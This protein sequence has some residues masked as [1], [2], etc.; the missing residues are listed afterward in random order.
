MG[1]GAPPPSAILRS[2]SLTSLAALVIALAPQGELKISSSPAVGLGLEAGV[3]RRDPSEVVRIGE[4]DYVCYTKLRTGRPLYPANYAGEIWYATSTDEGHTWVE[5][6]RLLGPGEAGTFDSIGVF[7]PALYRDPRGELQLFYSGVGPLFNFRFESA[8]KVEPIRIGVARLELGSRPGRLRALRSEESLPVFAP[9]GRETH[10]FDSLRVSNP[11]PLLRNGLVYLYYDGHAY[12]ELGDAS[13]LGLAVA[14]SPGVPFHRH[15]EGWPVLPFSGDAKVWNRQGGVMALLTR[16]H[17]GLYFAADGEHFSKLPVRVSG[18]L[19]D[20]G[21]ALPTAG[22]EDSARTALWGIHVARSAPDPYL[23][24]FEFGLPAELPSAPATVI[25]VPSS[26]SRATAAGWLEGGNWLDQH[27]AI[28]G[29]TAQRPRGFVFLGDS[30]TQGWGGPD[31]RVRAIGT[32][33]WQEHLGRWEISNYGI[34]GDRTQHILWRIGH[35]AF[36]RPRFRGIVLMVGT[37][38][39]GHDSPESIAAGIDA[40]LS[41][42]RRVAPFAEIVLMALTPRGETADDAARLEVEEIN[43]RIAEFDR[44]PSVHFL[45]LAPE[46]LDEERR[47]RA[48]LFAPDFLHLSP[49]GYEVWAEALVPLFEKIDELVLELAERKLGEIEAELPAESSTEGAD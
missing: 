18:R 21:L 42:L 5:R 45:D 16:V 32:E 13:G 34:S 19:N 9:S 22:E 25:P 31:R 47:A 6:G 17:R 27:E 36:V 11:A 40:I 35:G 28:L 15:H 38:N 10:S 8:A 12:G 30:I 29:R 26:E 3:G 20:A 49:A 46:L 41:R 48:E 2:M 43:R 33:A 37:N 7:D 14:T 1:M 23:E 24:R 39:V 4:F 44:L